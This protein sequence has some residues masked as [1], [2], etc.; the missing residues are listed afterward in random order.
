LA[1]LTHY[2]PIFTILWASLP[3]SNQLPSS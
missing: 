2:L 1:I 3:V